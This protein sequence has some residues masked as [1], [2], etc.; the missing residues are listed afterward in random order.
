MKHGDT[1]M[2]RIEI[3][4]RGVEGFFKIVFSFLVFGS[5]YNSVSCGKK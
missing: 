5:K 3:R 2:Q 4:G 1:E